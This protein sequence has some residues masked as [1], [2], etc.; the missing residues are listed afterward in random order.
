M[1]QLL[2]VRDRTSSTSLDKRAIQSLPAN[3]LSVILLTGCSTI[4]VHS[5]LDMLLARMPQASFKAA[6]CCAPIK[7]E[8]KTPAYTAQRAHSATIRS[9]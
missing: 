9:M 7:T 3:V 8:R 2:N 5:S 4:H 6:G 1:L